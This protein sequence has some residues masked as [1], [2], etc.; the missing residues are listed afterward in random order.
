[1]TGGM[2]RRTALVAMVLAGAGWGAVFV[3]PELAP[4]A[5]ALLLAMGRFVA[6]GAVSLPQLRAV[7]R[8]DVPWVRV[9]AH[10]VTGSLLYYGL[11]ALAVRLAGPTIAV[12]TIGLV[13]VVMALISARHRGRTG[14]VALVPALALV[15][16]G[17]V[18]VHLTPTPGPGGWSLV[19][20]TVL[21]LIAVASWSWYGLDSHR[22]L[23]ARPD[24][25]PV[26]AGAQGLAA[27]VLALPLGA[28]LIATEGVPAEPVRALLVVLFLGLVSSWL[29]V[30]LWHAA[31][32][33]LSPVLV[34]QLMATETAWGF[35]FAAVLAGAVP[36]PVALLGEVALVAGVALAVVTDGH[37]ERRERAHPSGA[38][39]GPEVFQPGVHA[40]TGRQESP[41][42]HGGHEAPGS[43]ASTARA[44]RSAASRMRDDR[45]SSA[46][47]CATASSSAHTSNPA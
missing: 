15:G 19:V 21:A 8:A 17:Q 40:D 41:H 44:T 1:M 28:W 6:F 16:V 9:V 20:G 11:V 30:R 35:V 13:P 42:D 32:A 31:A 23:A 14:L 10:A 39:M 18:L 34:S 45:G 37:R 25:G 24:L 3:A 26:L 47:A 38:G 4:L 27:G 5:P 43:S 33:R 22:L 7:L 12:A 46:E 29:A 2:S 36:G